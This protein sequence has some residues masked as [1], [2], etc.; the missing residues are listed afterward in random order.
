M[1]DLGEENFSEFAQ[2]H[3]ASSYLPDPDYDVFY[4][5]ISVFIQNRYIGARFSYLLIIW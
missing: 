1:N 3:H 2:P 4:W 5:W